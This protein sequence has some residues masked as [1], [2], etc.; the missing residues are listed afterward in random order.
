MNENILEPEKCL[1][2]IKKKMC[3]DSVNG[4]SYTYE[5]KPSKESS[6][7]LGQYF[8]LKVR[9]VKR[10]SS[11]V[12]KLNFFIKMLPKKG[13]QYNFIKACGFFE[14]ELGLY[15]KIFPKILTSKE[16]N[17][18]PEC[19]LCQKDHVLVFEDMS[20]QGY[21]VLDKFQYLQLDQFL[22]I[23]K[24]LARF[25]ARSLIFEEKNRETVMQ[26][27]HA[28]EVLINKNDGNLKS[29]LN[30]RFK[31]VTSMVDLLTDIDFGKKEECKAKI[32][33]ISSHHYE[34]SASSTKFRN[35]LCHRDLWNS[36][37]LFK[38]NE[39]GNDDH[40]CFVDFQLARYCPPAYDLL[41]FLYC[42]TSRNFRK[43]HS[44]EILFS[45]Y[46]DTLTES[47]KEA[48]IDLSASFS[49]NDF[50]ESMAE[51]KLSCMV[52]GF[53]IMSMCFL[54][55]DASVQI[56]D[57][58]VSASQI[59][60][61]EFREN[62]KCR[63]L[64]V[65]HPT[66]SVNAYSNMQPCFCAAVCVA[67]VF[68]RGKATAHCCAHSR[69]LANGKLNAALD[70]ETGEWRK[71]HNDELHALYGA[72][73]ILRV[74]KARKLRWAGHVARMGNDRSVAQIMQGKPNS[75]RPLGRPRIRWR[76]NL[77]KDLVELGYDYNEWMDDAHDRDAWRSRVDEAM[78][79]RVPNADK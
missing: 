18:V 73:N 26:L 52:H 19:F 28:N 58:S 64:S 72:P 21:R 11:E 49:W 71:L 53:S 74:M 29:N 69:K 66:A 12:K 13:V 27:C 79:F 50:I 59:V 4:F 76:D 38:N 2:I 16:T 15:E 44:T 54:G 41:Y 33:R 1:E 42:T 43:E 20:L 56:R 10:N 77:K 5:F 78:N 24:H 75:K 51:I 32:S 67:V 9:L 61:E 40:C 25:H 31:N 36:N 57:E 23:V 37:I 70:E 14:I 55:P 39:N 6:G 30:K 22:I 35:V 60:C 47:L 45:K 48:K 65:Y 62:E 63:L 3:L 46:Y 17:L 34:K 8:N 68:L 7:L